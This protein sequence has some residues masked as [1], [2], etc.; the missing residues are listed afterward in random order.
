MMN[1]SIAGHPKKGC[2]DPGHF[3]QVL[4]QGTPHK[5]IWINIQGATTVSDKLFNFGNLSA[6][7]PDPMTQSKSTIRDT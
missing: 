7:L 1:L 3:G 2:T 4:L 5:L 6:P